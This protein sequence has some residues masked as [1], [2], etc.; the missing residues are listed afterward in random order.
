MRY[1][2]ANH[3]SDIHFQNVSSISVLAEHIARAHLHI[4][5][6]QSQIE[7]ENISHK[8]NHVATSKQ[9]RLESLSYYA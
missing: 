7:K 9:G 1:N 4:N 6:A 3:P 5:S 2:K 8:G